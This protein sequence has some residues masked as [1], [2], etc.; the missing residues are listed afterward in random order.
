[1]IAFVLV[2]AALTDLTRELLRAFPPPAQCAT[3][4]SPVIALPDVD[5]TTTPGLVTCPKCGTPQ[6]PLRHRFAVHFPTL[7]SARP[8]AGS[9]P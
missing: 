7:T 6:R 3:G 8:C 2:M 1:M 5:E 9:W 4:S